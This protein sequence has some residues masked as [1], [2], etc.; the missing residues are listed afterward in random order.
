[1][2]PRI[3]RAAL[4]AAAACLFTAPALAAP[5]DFDLLAVQLRVGIYPA[6]G[7]HAFLVIELIRQ[8]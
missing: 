1:M 7:E 3:M 5:P 8:S 2:T 4:P 6:L